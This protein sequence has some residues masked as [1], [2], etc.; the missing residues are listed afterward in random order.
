MKSFIIF[1]FVFFSFKP[2]AL[3]AQE[4]PKIITRKKSAI[5][6]ELLGNSGTLFS[7]NYDRILLQNYYGYLDGSIGFGPYVMDNGYYQKGFNIPI[8]ANYSYGSKNGHLELG[9]GVGIN[10]AKDTAIDIDFVRLLAHFRIGYKYQNPKGGAFF[11]VGFT[12]IVPAYYFKGS[13][14]KGGFHDIDLFLN[15]FSLGLGFSF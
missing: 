1:L 7:I 3:F 12:P 8:A 9:L 2:S 10:R 13:V 6:V 4:N 14:P 15:A 5:Y 11:K